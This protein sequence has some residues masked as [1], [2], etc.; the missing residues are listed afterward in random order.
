MVVNSFPLPC[1]RWAQPI[2]AQPQANAFPGQQA[3]HAR[4]VRAE[5]A[6]QGIAGMG[7]NLGLGDE[8]G[9]LVTNTPSQ[10]PDIA[11]SLLGRREVT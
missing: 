4:G 2:K 7:W 1:N 5:T 10:I 8:L 3:L 6:L 9:H 11:V